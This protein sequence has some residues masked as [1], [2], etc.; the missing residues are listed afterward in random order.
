MKASLIGPVAV[1][2]GC[3][4]G[5]TSS[6]DKSK[7]TDDSAKAKDVPEPNPVPAGP[8][9]PIGPPTTMEPL[10]YVAAAAVLEKAV[11]G[12][13]EKL[14]TTESGLQYHVVAEGDGAVLQTGMAAKIQYTGRL[15]D[16]TKFDSSLDR[17]EPFQ[18]VLG[19]RLVIA[20][21][22]QGLVG[23][24]LGGRRILV[25]PPE[26]GYGAKEYAGRIPANSVLV[27]DL[28]VLK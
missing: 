3:G 8:R 25:V 9:R 7:K 21:W 14:N 24:K 16:G 10:K 5:S 28:E 4:R 12:K 26:L 13:V 17:K 27:F 15:T 6:R 19:S 18:V 2:L 1:V 22:E 23:M 11:G 20:G